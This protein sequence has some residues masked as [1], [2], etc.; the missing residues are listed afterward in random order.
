MKP[1][2]PHA[3]RAV[4]VARLSDPPVIARCHQ[5]FES[6]AGRICNYA[7]GARHFRPGR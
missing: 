1:A 2:I 6:E 4:Q 5:R 3:V 7:T